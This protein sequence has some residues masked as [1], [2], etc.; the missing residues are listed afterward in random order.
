MFVVF[1]G[2]FV[3]SIG[4]FV[5]FCGYSCGGRLLWCYVASIGCLGSVFLGRF[6][7]FLR[8]FFSGWG[9]SPDPYISC[10]FPIPMVFGRAPKVF[11]VLSRP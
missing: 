7:F 10:V 3:V 2:F 5:L 9:F 4:C 6:V 1:L 11:F 8:L